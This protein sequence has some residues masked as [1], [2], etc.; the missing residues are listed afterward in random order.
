MP[1]R[2]GLCTLRG[3]SW[4]RAWLLGVQVE[5]LS[6]RLI[7]IPRIRNLALERGPVRLRRAL[8][9]TKAAGSITTGGEDGMSG[10]VTSGRH[11]SMRGWFGN[12]GVR[13]GGG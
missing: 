5:L 3:S 9:Q 13:P 2:L 6:D 4:A 7:G 8:Y 12:L 10:L 11:T 1:L